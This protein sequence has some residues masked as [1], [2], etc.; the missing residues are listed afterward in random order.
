MIKEDDTDS[1][2]VIHEYMTD[3]TVC[4]ATRVA[5]ESAARAH[6]VRNLQL[7]RSPCVCM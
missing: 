1:S 4:I 3:V 6:G 2:S 5:L 7:L